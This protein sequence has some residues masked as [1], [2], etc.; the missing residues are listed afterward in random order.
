MVQ[1]GSV[2]RVL[3]KESY[4]YQDLGTV[5]VVD[6]SGV[7]YPAVVRF[8]KVNYSNINTNNFS[9]DELVEVKAPP[10]KPAA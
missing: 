2:V 9:L 1:K 6:S 3:R 8:D 5:T 7:R 10:A 4:W